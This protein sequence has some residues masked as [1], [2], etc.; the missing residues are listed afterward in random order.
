MNLK[1]FYHFLTIQAFL[2]LTDK[3]FKNNYRKVIWT[4]DSAK[5]TD[6]FQND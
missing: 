5:L 1:L 2:Q 6:K 3:L 4:K